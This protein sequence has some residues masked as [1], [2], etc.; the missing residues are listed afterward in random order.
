MTG[1]QV[2]LEELSRDEISAR[3][4][5]GLAVLPIGATEQHGPHLPTGT[6]TIHT[7]H[8]VHAAAARIAAEVP[9]VVAP[10]LPY[11]CSPHHLPFGATMSLRSETFLRVVCELAASLVGAGFR[12]LFLVNGHGGNDELV[13]V[14]AREVALERGVRVGACSW[15]ALAREP[16]LDA[17]ADAGSLPGHAGAFETSLILAL[18]PE[19][20]AEQR[21]HRDHVV[22][23]PRSYP[24]IVVS[25][26]DGFWQAIDGYTD[27]PDKSRADDGRTWLEVAAEVLAEALRDFAT[28]P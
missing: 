3:A 20:V 9:V 6:D 25:E 22:S 4:Y 28:S 5:D 23:Q 14:A 11:G 21:P 2:L 27:S 12:R 24:R 10:A 13:R 1:R 15:W 19:L 18:R 26:G 16:L 8:V 17:G 7:A